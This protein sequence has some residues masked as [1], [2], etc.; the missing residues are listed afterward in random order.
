MAMD[1]Y[2]FSIP[3]LAGQLVLFALLVTFGWGKDVNTDAVAYH[4]YSGSQL[5]ENRLDKDYFAASAQGYFNPLVHA[6]F[7][8]MV[9]AK[10]PD[11]LIGAV[12]AV[13]SAMSLVMLALLYQQILGLR[14]ATLFWVLLLSLVSGVVWSGMGTSTPDLFLQLPAFAA[15]LFLFKARQE[16]RLYWMVLSGLLWGIALGLKL[17]AIIYGPAMFLLVCYWCWRRYLGW[18]ALPV[19][20]CSVLAGFVLIDG[21][22]A[23]QL[24]HQF[25]N[26]FFPLFNNWFLSPDYTLQSVE[27]R[28]F[29]S[30]DIYRQLLLPFRIAGSEPLTYIEIVAPDIR[31]AVFVTLFLGSVVVAATT[32]RKWQL[33]AIEQDFVIFLFVALYTWVLVSG[34]G[35]YA[36]G[37][38]LMIGAGI[39]LLLKLFLTGRNLRLMFGIIL[40]LQTVIVLCNGLDGGGFKFELEK[41]GGTWFDSELNYRFG[42]ELVLMGTPNPYSII[43]MAAG[44]NTSFIATSSSYLL[45]LNPAIEKK[46]KEHENHILGV[47][48][49]PSTGIISDDVAQ[50]TLFQT[51]SRLGLSFDV[52]K[53]CKK[54]QA[55]AHDGKIKHKFLACGLKVDPLARREYLSR[56]SHAEAYFSELEKRCPD[57]FTPT[58]NP[59]E[60]VGSLLKKLYRGSEVEVFLS[61]DQKVM[62]KRYWSVAYYSLGNSES[63]SQMD[64]ATWKRRYCMPLVKSG[65]FPSPASK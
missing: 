63:F 34:N 31:P 38:L 26:P 9:R 10:W 12:L 4:Y 59:V 24:Y 49:A 60:I 53:G 2:L 33:A 45:T 1:R 19:M 41:W 56:V 22:W 64:D 27:D 36:T 47:I 55:L 21:W 28:R 23:I 57:A 13:Y 40:S 43:V 11:R 65:I 25:G 52:Q 39:Y 50:E 16:N 48:I 18:Y 44:M 3:A 14:R 61:N 5:F 62:A 15:I 32:K 20:A 30:W 17:S 8:A 7:A 42:D 29:L 51:F 46:I 37:L 35:R 6:P 58:D 54:L